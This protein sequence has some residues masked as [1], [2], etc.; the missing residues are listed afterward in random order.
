MF[1]RVTR[2]GIYGE[3]GKDLETTRAWR[4]IKDEPSDADHRFTLYTLMGSTP[5]FKV[6]FA[7]DRQFHLDQTAR[8]HHSRSDSYSSR[9]LRHPFT[10]PYNLCKQRK[11]TLQSIM[12][13]KR[14]R[15]RRQLGGLLP[16][17]AAAAAAG[18]TAGAVASK[19]LA[20]QHS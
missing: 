16:F 5:S 19:I 14:T 20:K 4:G 6:H 2:R 9:Y 7:E 8:P 12:R 13:R 10:L 15:H 1:S 11:H 17:L 18:L 3:N